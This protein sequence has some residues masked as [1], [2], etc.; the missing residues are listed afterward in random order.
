MS[1][2]VLVTGGN[3][4]IGLAVARRFAD[5]G[6]K[7]V[8][9]HR[10]GTPP[11]GTSGVFCEITDPAS[12]A[13]AVQEA[14]ALHGPVEVLVANAGITRDGLLLGMSDEDFVEVVT[15]NLLGAVRAA[16][17]VL[18]DMAKAR[19]GRIVFV[20][21][22]SGLAGSPGQTNYTAA[23]AGLLGFARSLAKEMG[24][25]GITVNVVSPGLI[26]TDMAQ[27]VTGS[28][29]DQ[30]LGETALRRAGTPEEVASAVHYLA[31][32]SAGYITGANLPV[33]GGGM[34]G[35]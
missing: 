19:R 26:D 3:R 13:A 9:T 24:P 15:T 22:V 23:K 2:S 27:G 31:S 4:G 33:S 7:V 14:R 18:T 32:E 12:V 21:S 17:E 29:R 34:L 25:R 30:L 16:R 5:S 20:S 35:N 28:R 6:D 11:E 1:R 8:V 10:S